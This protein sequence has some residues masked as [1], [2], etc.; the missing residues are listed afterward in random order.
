ME[1]LIKELKAQI[2]AM[3]KANGANTTLVTRFLIVCIQSTP[4]TSLSTSLV[5]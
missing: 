5:T 3:N 2:A 4:S 1:K